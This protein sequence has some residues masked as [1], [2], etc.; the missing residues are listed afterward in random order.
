[1]VLKLARIDDSDVTYFNGQILGSTG[2][3][4]P[5]YQSGYGDPRVYSLP[6]ERVKWGA[7]NTL[8]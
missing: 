8:L 3:L 4:P 6:V 1:M 2:V 7:Q 5:D